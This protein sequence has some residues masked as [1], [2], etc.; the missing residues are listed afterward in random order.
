[1]QSSPPRRQDLPTQTQ[2]KRKTRGFWMRQN[3][4]QKRFSI[5]YHR[6]W[7][8]QRLRGES[9]AKS[10]HL[11]AWA[12]LCW[13][14][15][16]YVLEPLLI[17]CKKPQNDIPGEMECNNPISVRL[18]CPG[19]WGLWVFLAGQLRA[20]AF[21]KVYPKITSQDELPTML[22]QKKYFRST[23]SLDV[24]YTSVGKEQHQGN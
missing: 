14:I 13:I 5:H 2:M 24:R 12:R 18:G 8:L 10:T 17:C 7:I 22:F 23:L 19:T 3:S 1:M 16:A 15:D 20:I 9:T 4:A 21:A 11:F 6:S